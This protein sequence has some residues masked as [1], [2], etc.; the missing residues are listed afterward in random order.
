MAPTTTA[1]PPI[2]AYL[3]QGGFGHA[4]VGRLARP[5]DVVLPV[6]KGLVSAVVPYA[7][8]LVLVADPDRT[9]LREDLDALSFTRGLPSLGLT[10]LP[11]ELRCGPLVIPGRTAC[12]GCYERRRRQHGYRPLPE[13]LGPLPQGYA[14]HHVVLGA[15]LVSMALDLLERQARPADGA[16]PEPAD[17]PGRGLGGQV[18]ALDLVSGST[19]CASTVA[20]DRCP[21]CSARYAHRRDGLPALAGLLPRRR[22]RQAVV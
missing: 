20:V 19:S 17:D 21:T 18:W 9:G 4:V 3:P 2:T 7:D 22:S 8:R 11:T 14:H 16:P 12:Y 10:L 15:G 13:G 1:P 5:Q 6:D